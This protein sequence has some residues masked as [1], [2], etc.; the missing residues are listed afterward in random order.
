MTDKEDFITSVYEIVRLIPYGRVTSYGAIA[1]AVGY[2][3]LSRMV[4]AVMGQC[5]ASIPAHRVVNSQGKLSGK[6]A[7]GHSE[8]MQKLLEMEGIIVKNDMIKNWKLVFWDPQVEIEL[9]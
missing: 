5:N 6:R 7:F 8:E 1:K 2:S 4:G 9:F 3:S